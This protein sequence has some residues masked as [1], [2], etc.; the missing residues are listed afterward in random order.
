MAD[1]T[2]TNDTVGITDDSIKRI[3][4]AVNELSEKFGGVYERLNY[5]GFVSVFGAILV[6]IPLFLGKLP[7]FGLT[8][9]E[10]K[11]YVIVGTSFVALGAIWITIQNALI[12][13]L[14]RAKQEVA[15]RM[16]AIKV[17][18]MGETQQAALKAMEET[19]SIELSDSP[20]QN[21]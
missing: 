8:F 21:K 9:D 11:L 12:Y 7:L 1:E 15:C 14:Q 16:L 18:A 6:F 3:T 17:A 10:Q 5:P 2:K 19:K 20:F 13:K 4:S